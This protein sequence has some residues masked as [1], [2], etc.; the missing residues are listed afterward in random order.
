M[1]C[2]GGHTLQGL[3]VTSGF[4]L[5]ITP[6]GLRIAQV[7][8]VIKW[9]LHA[10]QISYLLHDHF[11]PS[12]MISKT[13]CPRASMCLTC[14]QPKFSPLVLRMVPWFWSVLIPEQR[15]KSKS[16]VPPDVTPK[17]LPQNK[18][19]FLN[20][21]TEVYSCFV[22]IYFKIGLYLFWD[23]RAIFGS[24]SEAMWLGESNSWF[25]MQDLD[26]FLEPLLAS[27]WILQNKEEK[28]KHVHKEKKAS[29]LRRKVYLSE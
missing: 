28:I 22:L 25:Q 21:E 5:S 29:F 4:V 3:V 1:V 26:L 8:L 23:P 13:I 17:P 16:W 10:R 19:F 12:L 2:F 24:V 11:G 9:R 6:G 15:A 20:R 27:A 18:L 14:S 7:I